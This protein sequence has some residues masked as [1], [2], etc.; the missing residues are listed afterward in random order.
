MALTSISRSS[1]VASPGLG[2][3]I[4]N[5]IGLGEKIQ[6]PL[7]NCKY[8]YIYYGVFFWM[9][10][11]DCRKMMENDDALGEKDVMFSGTHLNFGRKQ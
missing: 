5:R 3:A 1:S 10:N 6:F 9:G 11:D 8:I 7:E 4:K 2:T